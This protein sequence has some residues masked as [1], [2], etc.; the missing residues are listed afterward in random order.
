M[1]E[2]PV[3]AEEMLRPLEWAVPAADLTAN[4]KLQDLLIGL[5]LLGTD[6]QRA[7]A[8]T[9]EWNKDTPGSIQVIRSGAM[10]I[11]RWWARLTRWVAGAGGVAAVLGTTAGAITAV[12]E[13]LGEPLIVALVAGGAVVTASALLSA[14]LLIKGDLEARGVATAAR[15]SG[16]AEVAAAFL[17]GTATLPGQ[18]KGQALA[19]EL[20]AA[21]SGGRPVFVQC[22]DLLD[23]Q[24][25]TGLSRVTA[26]GY[27]VNLGGD[28][29]RPIEHVIGY[30][31]EAPPAAGAAPSAN[32][33]S[34]VRKPFGAR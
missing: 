20:T 24:R 31:I 8:A 7:Q 2:K 21:L 15:N 26:G 16:R 34:K 23:P 10:G 30:R 4:V 28:L 33:R 5:Q 22:Q 6:E 11:T 17:T 1:A 27:Q 13:A 25:V 14:A 19:A 12:R 3:G 18:A 32:G 29:W 9:N